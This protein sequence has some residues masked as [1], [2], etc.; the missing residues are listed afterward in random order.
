M[1]RRVITLNKCREAP[2]KV[3]NALCAAVVLLV[4]IASTFL[5]L[6]AI[7]AQNLPVVSAG[8]S[9][10]CALTSL[11]GGGVRCWGA[12]SSGQLGDGTATNRYVPT[13]VPGLV[14][15]SAVTAGA[16]HTCALKSSDGG[17][18]CWGSNGVGQLGNG[19]GGSSSTPVAVVDGAS[20][21]ITGAV[22]ISAGLNHSCAL[23]SNGGVKCW[24]WNTSGQLGDGS[25]SSR[26]YAADVSGYTSGVSRITAG[27]YHTCLLVT[28]TREIKCFGSNIYGG[29]G[30]GTTI[31]RT[32]P[33]TVSGIVT[34]QEVAGGSDL[35]CAKLQDGS[36]RCWGANG[37]GSLGDGTTVD[38]STPV[39]VGVIGTDGAL[40]SAGGYQSGGGL[41]RFACATLSSTGQV[42]CWGRGG[43]G[44]MGNGSLLDQSTPVFVSDTTG[45]VAITAGGGHACVWIGTCT[46]KCWGEN[47]TGTVGDG[48]QLNKT[49]P[50]TVL[51]CAEPTPTPTH[52]PTPT[53]TPTATP[54]STPTLAVPTTAPALTPTPDA[55]SSEKSCVPD[56]SLTTPLEPRAPDFVGTPVASKSSVSLEV[57]AVK[58]GVPI[59]P[60]KQTKLRTRLQKFFGLKITSL[61]KAIRS[62][63]V[64]Y[65]ISIVRA[66]QA[67][68]ADV[69]AEG[70]P[71]KYKLE[72]RKRRV[73][74]RLAP[75]T[76]VATVAV[77]VKN[78]R[79]KTFVTGKPS[80]GTTFVVK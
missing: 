69:E 72:T 20:S 43:E 75:G 59:D 17:V 1:R 48:T 63:R 47:T 34:A 6:R 51:T 38:S 7:L 49:T 76:Y 19:S 53:Q 71:T 29:L 36:L 77:R 4:A 58:L 62:L 8:S 52:T 16:S 32:S 45:A 12:N 46:V 23:F 78:A 35:T 56:S 27:A 41:Y 21:P 80:L 67:Q 39:T 30:D 73:T 42:L 26:N 33:V 37:S 9:H 31:T 55:C 18:V 60:A 64:F 65:V 14:G 79:G 3:R 57:G 5:P 13:D 61:S 50:V 66:K 15:V 28:A 54:T 24:G 44:Q 22:A 25:T 10:T 68:A 40:I 70:L 74:A 11:S 2:R